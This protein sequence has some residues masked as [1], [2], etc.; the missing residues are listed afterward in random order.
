[1]LQTTSLQPRL[2]VFTVGYFGLLMRILNS[3]PIRVQPDVYGLWVLVQYWYA[4]CSFVRDILQPT[5][6]AGQGSLFVQ[7]LQG[8]CATSPQTGQG[9]LRHAALERC[10]V[11]ASGRMPLSCLGHSATD[12][13]SRLGARCLFS[14]RRR[15][16]ATWLGC[17]AI[18]GLPLSS[19]RGRE[20]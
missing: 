12:D 3:T 17:A 16:R 7:L 20:V 11:V 8:Q 2:R 9:V 15:R 10:A 6:S 1:M 4:C 19:R 14:G 13:V 18:P 5:P